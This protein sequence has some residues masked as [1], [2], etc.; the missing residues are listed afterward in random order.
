MQSGFLCHVFFLILVQ[1]DFKP[2]WTKKR[3]IVTNIKIL[4]VIAA[5]ATTIA[6]LSLFL[7]EMAVSHEK[8]E[9]DDKDKKYEA[10]EVHDKSLKV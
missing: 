3:I 1:V 7:S 6:V 9:T 2:A 4:S 10:L 8:E 5:T